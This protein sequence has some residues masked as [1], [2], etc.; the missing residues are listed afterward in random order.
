MT[1][2]SQTYEVRPG[3]SKNHFQIGYE[4]EVETDKGP[5]KKFRVRATSMDKARA[6]ELR[7]KFQQGGPWFPVL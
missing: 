5:E 7:E 4:E 1:T 3:P 6:E 2:S